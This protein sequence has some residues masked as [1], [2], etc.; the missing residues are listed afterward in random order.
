MNR[1]KRTIFAALAGCALAMVA[2]QAAAQ[3]LSVENRMKPICAGCHWNDESQMRGT[4]VPGS[5]NDGSF[6]LET[7]NKV[8]QV[9]Y[10]Q[11]SQLHKFST[12][13][14]LA[15]EKALTV[16]FQHTRG[17]RVYAEEIG[18]KPNLRFRGHRDDTI[19]IGEVNELLQQTPEQGNY[20]I[21]DARGY[22]NYIEGHLPHAVLIPHYRF[23]EFKHR[24]PEDKNKT[25]VVYCRGYG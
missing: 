17:N 13:K 6:K 18:Y 4:L 22:D 20:M 11:D 16:R 10:D 3:E 24:L 12:I 15:D 2:S 14:D 7:G 21:I 19:T 5:K 23:S 9:R 25:L 8:W 1:G